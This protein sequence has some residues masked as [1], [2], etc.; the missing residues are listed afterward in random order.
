MVS[1]I[2][3]VL[4]DFTCSGATHNKPGALCLDCYVCSAERFKVFTRIIDDSIDVG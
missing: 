4:P 1:I 3:Y 2:T